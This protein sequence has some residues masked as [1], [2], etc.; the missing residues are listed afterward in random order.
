MKLL[1]D[2]N[3]PETAAIL[4]RSAGLDTVH[5]REVGLAYADD[6]EILAWS[7]AE[8][9]MVITLDADFHALLALSGATK[10][11]VIRIRIE[12]LAD[13]ALVDLISSVT[14]TRRDDLDSGAAISVTETA[15]RTHR[16]PLV[17][18]PAE[19]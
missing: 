2:Q 8:D 9:R 4:L 13:R 12:G 10:P 18:E 3:L 5:T 7:R 11:S 15:I 19:E 17:G 14:A 1:L 16:L 6:D